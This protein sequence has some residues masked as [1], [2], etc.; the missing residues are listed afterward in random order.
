MKEFNAVAEI[1]ALAVRAKTAGNI[2]A[3]RALKTALEQVQEVALA[4]IPDTGPLTEEEIC[5]VLGAE[6]V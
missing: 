5:A 2:T 4:K 3:F 6:R 1:R